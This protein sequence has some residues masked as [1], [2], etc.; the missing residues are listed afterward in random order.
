M[1]YDEALAKY[2]YDLNV[3]SN[4]APRPANAPPPGAVPSFDI[5]SLAPKIG[6][7]IGKTWATD[8]LPA[9]L[10]GGGEIAANVGENIAFNEAAGIASQNAWNAGANLATELS[11]GS[12][13]ASMGSQGAQ[14]AN[15]APF[16][17]YIGPTLALS[18]I[19]LGAY[20]MFGEKKTPVYLT[21]FLRKK[22]LVEEGR[23]PE[24]SL[25]E[26][27]KLDNTAGRPWEANSKYA[28]SRNIKDL[29]G[30][31]IKGSAAFY[32]MYPEWGKYAPDTQSNIAKAF[33]D[34]GSAVDTR[35][36]MR[37]LN[38]TLPSREEILKQIAGGEGS[39]ANNAKR[40]SDYDAKVA[41]QEELNKKIKSL[42]EAK[43]G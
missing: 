29:S 37:L 20:K 23:L 40:L 17:A 2:M 41:N 31:D 5:G 21:E 3:A 6:V 15:A 27:N 18:Q 16:G 35:G 42:L 9:W 28:Q 38:P 7:K 32:E 36:S 39:V 24:T 14:V 10:G 26:P 13:V 1:N 4:T 22:K 8:G 43:S 33:I 11:Q 12:N 34:H 19:A 25:W 30:D